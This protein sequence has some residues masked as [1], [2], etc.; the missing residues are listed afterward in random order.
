MGLFDRLRGVGDRPADQH[1]RPGSRVEPQQQPAVTD[2]SDIKNVLAKW[3]AEPFDRDADALGFQNGMRLADQGPVPGQRFNCAEYMSRGLKHSL[4]GEDLFQSELIAESL[5][6]CLLLL[7]GAPTLGGF[8]DEY[9]LTIVRLVLTIM[10]QRG[11]QTVELA[12]DGTVNLNLDIGLVR[13]ALRYD[14]IE[15]LNIVKH[16]FGV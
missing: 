7:D 13:E 1:S 8:M 6:K 12:G 3:T 2:W 15:P 11:W 14:P 16:F 5:P 9:R 10:R 4:R